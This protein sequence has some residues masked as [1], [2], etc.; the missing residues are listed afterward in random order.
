V[1]Q[2][3]SVVRPTNAPAFVDVTNAWGLKFKHMVGPL[4]T[5]FMPESVGAGGA[6][7]DCD[8]DGR[9]DVLLVQSHR[10]PNA[11]GSFPPGSTL[12]C[13][14]FRQTEAGAFE[15]VSESSGLSQ[16]DYGV[17]CAVGDVDN[18]GDLDLYIT[19]YRQDRLY[20][21]DASGKFHDV[22]ETSGIEETDWGTCAAFL[23]YNRD[24]WLD[25]VVVNY[26]VDPLYDHS[27][28]CGFREGLVSYCGPQKFQ[29]TVDRLYRNDGPQ[30]DSQGNSTVH[31]TDVTDASGLGSLKTFG[32]GV[33]CVDVNA[34]GWQDIFVANDGAMNRLWINQKDGTFTDEAVVRGCAA[35]GDGNAEA[36]MG[37]AFGDVAH[38]GL[39]DFVV[40]HLSGEKATLYR[41]TREGTFEDASRMAG[42]VE[43]TSRH[44][45]W[46]AALIDFNHDGELDLAIAN[47]LVIPCHSKFPPHGEDNFQVRHDV[48]HDPDRFWRDYAD[49]NVFFMGRGNGH[50]RDA[51]GESGA[52]CT[53]P[54]SGRALI[55]GDI[56]N[57]GDIDLVVTNC[58]GNA[59]LYRN[60]FSKAGH[61]LMVRAFDPLLHRD[62]IGAEIRVRVRG[63]VYA[64]HVTSASSYLASNDLRVHFGLA[65][66][67]AYEQI[68]V[69][70]PDGPVEQA[71]EIFEGGQA[72]RLITLNRG[73]GIVNKGE[74]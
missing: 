51:T 20:L 40:T 43:P 26:T 5:Y 15:D 22:T 12:G 46:G 41:A 1:D 71:H 66:S 62:A 44:T 8:G 57:D 73:S 9:L 10:S 3:P 38:N 14:L 65:D 69:R 39:T 49:Q 50:F 4:G 67:D 59:R 33:V 61:W 23:D 56:D 64:G 35:N 24:G 52:F 54:G 21:N 31:F 72:N 55:H 42:L 2:Q 16:S 32:F 25:L 70:W 30:I 36:G 53:N 13:R 68:L 37:I 7:F 28:A 29:P 60:D 45:G 19:C 34:D 48:I 47:G 18:D 63:K 11:V 6:L 27:V 17:G 74:P 58:G